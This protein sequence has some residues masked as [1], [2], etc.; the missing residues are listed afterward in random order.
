MCELQ[1]CFSRSSESPDLFTYLFSGGTSGCAG[2]IT[3]EALWISQ[4]P[5][6][7]K[8]GEP[9]GLFHAAYTKS[10]ILTGM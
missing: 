4:R 7:R 2:E 10:F 8:L 5:D 6:D 9:E 1:F 3:K